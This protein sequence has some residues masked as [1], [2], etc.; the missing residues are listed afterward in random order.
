MSVNYSHFFY[1]VALQE[2]ELLKISV[3][4]QFQICN[5]LAN[6]DQFKINY[7]IVS[8]PDWYQPP[9][10]NKSWIRP[11]RGKSPGVSRGLANAQPPGRA[12]IANAPPP[13]LTRHANGV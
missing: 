5:I 4:P 10:S 2:L 9:P 13:G 12:K 1:F 11:V 7:D 6:V 3:H 8:W